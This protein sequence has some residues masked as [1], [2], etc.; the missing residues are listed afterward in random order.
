MVADH[1]PARRAQR[2]GRLAER[3]R[4]GPQRLLGRD[5]DDRQD[6][7]AERQDAGQ[8]RRAQRQ[9]LDP[10]RPHEQRQAQDAV[11]DRRHAG[12]VGDVGLDDA[13]QPARRGVFLEEDPAPMPIGIPIRATRP[14]SQRL[15]DDPDRISRRCAG[16]CD[17]GSVASAPDQGEQLGEVR[18]DRVPG[19]VR[20]SLERRR[21]DRAQQHE[22]D[23]DARAGR[24]PGRPP[25]RSGRATR[26]SQR[27][28]LK[29]RLGEQ[30]HW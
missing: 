10:E 24:Q 22:Q 23:D 26:R 16:R 25:R 6:Q 17:C 18:A 15:P 19:M 1:L 20:R 21:Q 9:G 7:Q 12:Q 8:Q 13:P 3:L 30:A 29:S 4:H 11:D 2:Q 28:G 27:L 14:S 5:H